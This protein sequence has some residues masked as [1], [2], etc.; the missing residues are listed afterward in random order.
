MWGTIA[1]GKRADLLLI[2]AN[3]LTD[4]EAVRDIDAVFVN[5]FHF[6]RNDLTALLEQRAASVAME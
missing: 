6:S 4:V 2:G 3:P 5:G 1:E